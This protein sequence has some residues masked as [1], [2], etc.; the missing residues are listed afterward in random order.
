MYAIRNIHRNSRKPGYIYAELHDLSQPEGD[1][2]II[3]ATLDYILD[4][5]KERGY[6]CA[7]AGVDRGPQK[8]DHS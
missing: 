1:R 5:I 7:E 4:A 3:V 8:S 6:E 2:R